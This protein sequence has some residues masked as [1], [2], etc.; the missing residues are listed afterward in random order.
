MFIETS[1]ILFTGHAVKRMFERSINRREVQDVLENGEIVAD[2]PDD[3]PFPSGLMLGFVDER[4]IH[5]VVAV[6]FETK[7]SYIVTAYDPDPDLWEL[8]FRNRRSQ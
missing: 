2:Y 6:E 5:V 8:D 3:Q 1:K 4:P 7:T